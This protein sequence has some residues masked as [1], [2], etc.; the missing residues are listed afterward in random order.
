MKAGDI[1][2]RSV[3][4]VGPFATIDLAIRIMVLNRV[5]GVPVVSSD[6]RL[7]GILT[8]GDLLRRV[9]TDTDG[10]RHPGFL[11]LLV[12][13]RHAADDY[14]RAHSR[15]VD[16]LMTGEVVTVTEEALLEGVVRLMEKHNIR[17]IPVVQGKLLAGIVSRA[18]L[19]AALGRKLAD[20]PNFQGSDRDIEANVSAKVLEM[21]CLENCRVTLKVH[22]GVV[23]LT[24][25]I[26]DQIARSA[27]R[28]AAETV[29]GVV[30]IEDRLVF[31]EPLIASFGPNP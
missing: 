14:V 12:R 24:G 8:Q 17:R 21:P 16:D 5:S 26:H 20:L 19:V 23:T 1:M 7:V 6:G 30:A 10:C 13:H 25:T 15:R 2:T 22:A 9:E 29:P 11:E 3:L 27:L 18:D 4:T 28:V 31:K